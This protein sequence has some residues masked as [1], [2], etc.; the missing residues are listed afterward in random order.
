MRRA[1]YAANKEKINAQK[2][3]TYSSITAG[4]QEDELLTL[5]TSF[6]HRRDKLYERTKLV[7]KVDGFEDV[8]GHGD[9]YSLVIKN[10]DNKEL[11]YI[12]A[13][14]VIDWLK[15]GGDYQGGDIRLVACSTGKEPAIVPRYLAQ[16]LN[17]SVMAPSEDV[18]I[19]FKGNI[20]LAD[21]EN[22]AKMGV[23]T[24]EWV[25]FHPDGS[26]TKYAGVHR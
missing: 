25:I 6:L 9:A 26:V 21:D 19:D 16:E 18:N 4:K 24:G 10:A 17:V 20:I 22:D 23:E 11:G 14:Q 8:F 5:S 15:Q 2:R 12:S 1:S 3:E 7:P 13:E